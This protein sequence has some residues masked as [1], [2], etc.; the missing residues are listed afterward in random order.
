MFPDSD[1]CFLHDVMREVGLPDL[2]QDLPEHGWLVANEQ[3]TEGLNVG[4]PR[5]FD[6]IPI[7]E[8]AVHNPLKPL[9]A[10]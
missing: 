3:N 1:E 7:W 5:F 4:I 9:V 10:T 8:L 2:K 6:E